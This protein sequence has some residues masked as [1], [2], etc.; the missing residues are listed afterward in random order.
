MKIKNEYPPNYKEI[1]QVFDLSGKKPIFT[2]GD[3][4]Y[5]PHGSTIEPHLEVHEQVHVEQ[6]GDDPKGWWDKYL[7]DPQFRLNQEL[8]AYGKQYQY[9]KE[10]LPNKALKHFLFLIASDLSSEM[11][12]SLLS[13]NEAESKIR[14]QAR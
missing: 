14:N 9:A 4:I 10:H 6:Q 11:Y 1:A 5:N 8:E 2:Y 12:G 7:V 13:H 3:T